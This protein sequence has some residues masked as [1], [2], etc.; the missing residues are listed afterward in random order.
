MG[1]HYPHIVSRLN[2]KTSLTWALCRWQRYLL[3]GVCNMLH[4]TRFW[5][6][7]WGEWI[8]KSNFSVV[9]IPHAILNIFLD[10]TRTSPAGHGGTAV[11]NPF[12]N[13]SRM[14]QPTV[15]AVIK[16]GDLPCVRMLQYFSSKNQTSEDGTPWNAWALSMFFDPFF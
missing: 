1:D 6:L 14:T 10:I 13:S 12:I 11:D 9:K 4:G 5:D 15:Y 2:Q 8:N 16:S 7:R 3:N